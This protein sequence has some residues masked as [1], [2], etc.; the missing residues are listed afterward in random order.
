MPLHTYLMFLPACFALNMAFGPNNVLSLSNGARIGVLHSVIAS[1]G[2]LVAFT[3]MI[4]ITGLGLGALLLTSATLFTVLKFAGAAC[5][6]WLGI[7][8]LR[9]KPTEQAVVVTEQ[10][11]RQGRTGLLLK[12]CRQEF[13]VAAGNPKAILIFTAFF[14]QFVDRTRY[15]V[16]FVVLG[17]TFLALELVAIAIYA[18]DRRA[19]GVPDREP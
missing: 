5:L 1:F 10:A 12:H 18:P 14:P 6:V 4:A 9:S 11:G 19:F 3:I 7:K 2:R 13:Y 16:S 15:A 8:L 17:A